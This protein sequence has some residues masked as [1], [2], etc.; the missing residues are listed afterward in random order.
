MMEAGLKL[1]NEADMPQDLTTEAFQRAHGIVLMESVQ[2][3]F[4]LSAEM[5]TGILMR[6]DPTTGKWSSPLAIGLTGVG[7]GFTFGAHKRNIVVFL[8]NEQMEKA[9]MSDFSITGGFDQAWAIGPIGE[10]NDITAQIGN[11]GTGLSSGHSQNVGI[12]TGLQAETA[13]MAPR[14]HINK[15]YYGEKLTPKEIVLEEHSDIMPKSELLDQLHA[16]LKAMT[17][18]SD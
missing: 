16:K 2:A 4:L 10:G 13:V 12:Y 7:G 11:A 6:K 17:E 8:N 15:K 18:G 5:G 14:T 9:A 1:L 3:G